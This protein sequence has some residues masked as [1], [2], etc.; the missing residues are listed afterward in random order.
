MAFIRTF[1]AIEASLEQ[2]GHARRL[3]E[4][5]KRAEANVN[6]V[7]AEN[8]HWTLKF[9]GD[10]DE[11]EIHNVCRAVNTATETVD[12]FELDCVGAGAFPD[13]R[14]PRTVWAGAGQGSEPA[15]SLQA[16]IDDALERLGYRRDGRQ[17][18]PHL[19]LGRVRGSAPATQ[20]LGE[21]I[22]QHDD[23]CV[24]KLIVDEVVVFSSRLNK[25][26]PRYTALAHSNLA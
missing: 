7:A 9:V 23:F 13:A 19:T 26:G 14:R 12:S 25:S 5:L 11:T 21:L 16:V 22:L 2:R 6:W 24:G 17:F 10:V 3:M 1:V 20:R 15:M 8:L 18:H 4:R